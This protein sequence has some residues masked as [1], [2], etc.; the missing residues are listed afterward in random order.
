MANFEAAFDRTPRSVSASDLKQY[1][2]DSKRLTL[3]TAPDY[4]ESS[5]TS[6]SS[7]AAAANNTADDDKVCAM[8][9]PA[10]YTCFRCVSYTCRETSINSICHHLWR[11]TEYCF[12]GI[13][14]T[15]Q[16][17]TP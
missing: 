17:C 6:S 2:R 5:S 15:A 10:I 4:V 7:A 11:F 12:A 9:S 13:V 1:T 8:L 14:V 16:L 3:I